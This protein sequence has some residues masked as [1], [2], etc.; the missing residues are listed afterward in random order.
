MTARGIWFC[1]C[2]A[3]TTR[4]QKS[5]RTVNMVNTHMC[6]LGPM[7]IFQAGKFGNFFRLNGWKTLIFWR[8]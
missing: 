8:I 4:G 1:K 5:I 7:V 2:I 3:E 6:I